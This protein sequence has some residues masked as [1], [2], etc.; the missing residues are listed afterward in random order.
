MTRSKLLTESANIMS[1]YSTVTPVHD[2]RRL[3]SYWQTAFNVGD[4]DTLMTMYE[5][6]A[7]IVPGP[8]APAVAGHDAIRQALV[9]FLE[10]GGTIRFTPRFWL[11]A[12]DIALGS[13]SHVMDGGQAPDGTPIDLRGVTTEVARRQPDGSWKYVIDHPFGGADEPA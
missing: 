11:V 7:V 6:N 3:N 10:L 4:L 1:Q 13:C 8:G 5:E 12:G 2:V 9:A